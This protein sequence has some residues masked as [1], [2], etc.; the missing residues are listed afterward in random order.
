MGAVGGALEESPP[1]SLREADVAHPRVPPTTFALRTTE[2]SWWS[3]QERSAP[4]TTRGRSPGAPLREIDASRLQ[5]RLLAR[6]RQARLNPHL[7]WPPFGE[8][9]QT[10]LH[11]RQRP[12][13]CTS[14]ARRLAAALLVS[15]GWSPRCPRAFAARL[16][17]ASRLHVAEPPSRPTL[18][19]A[20]WHRL[21]RPRKQG[22]NPWPTRST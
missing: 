9:V 18:P 16:P 22:Q 5:V 8:F 17:L 11:A 13:V 21:L 10:L 1:S 2:N 20:K 7:G 15:Q 6:G 14:L 3:W 19:Q 12:S 4:G